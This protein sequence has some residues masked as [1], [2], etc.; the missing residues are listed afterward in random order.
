MAENIPNL[1]MEIR[2]P[3]PGSQITTFKRNPRKTTPRYIVM[4][5]VRIKKEMLKTARN[6]QIVTYMGNTTR[7]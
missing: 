7:L 6:R 1:G 3:G 2:H 4:K 5:M